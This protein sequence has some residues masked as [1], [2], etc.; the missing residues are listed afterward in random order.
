MKP[1]G[2]LYQYSYLWF[3]VFPLAMPPAFSYVLVP[4]LIYTSLY[5]LHFRL[6]ANP[7]LGT[8]DFFSLA[9]VLNS[10]IAFPIFYDFTIYFRKKPMIPAHFMLRII[11]PMFTPVTDRIIY[12]FLGEVSPHDKA[13]PCCPGSRIFCWTTF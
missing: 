6:Q 9:L 2:N 12:I 3:I 4:L 5:L 1:E 10:L 13:K 11:F 8:V 7:V